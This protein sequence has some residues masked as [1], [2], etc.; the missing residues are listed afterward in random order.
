[1]I[2]ED[3]KESFNEVFWLE[4]AFKLGSHCVSWVN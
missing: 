1:L 2:I 4:D 3:S